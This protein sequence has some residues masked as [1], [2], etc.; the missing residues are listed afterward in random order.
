[1]TTA[2]FTAYRTTAEKSLKVIRMLFYHKKA[3]ST[4]TTVS[5]RPSH[6]SVD[7]W[8]V[9]SA[10]VP[11]PTRKATARRRHPLLSQR[12]H[13]R[14]WRHPPPRPGGAPFPLHPALPAQQTTLTYSRVRVCTARWI[15]RTTETACSLLPCATRTGK[16]HRRTRRHRRRVLPTT[17]VQ[18]AQ[19]PAATLPVRRRNSG[20][21]I[22][23]PPRLARQGHHLCGCLFSP[24][25]FPRTRKA[26]CWMK[27]SSGMPRAEA[28]TKS[29]EVRHDAL[30]EA[31][32]R[33]H[34]RGWLLSFLFFAPN[35]GQIVVAVAAPPL[36]LRLPRAQRD[37]PRRT[38]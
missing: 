1:M 38:V 3:R 37:R 36:P 2:N 32:R 23:S 18:T 11:P 17:T 26:S 21:S 10:S 12:A 9:T 22:R 33:I 27:W 29:V 4:T 25:K 6:Q 13:G 35:R 8:A 5:L 19:R 24:R 16:R 31:C 34:H 28:Q 15:P 30:R 20:S 7:R 14:S